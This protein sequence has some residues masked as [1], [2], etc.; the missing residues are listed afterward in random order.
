M[1]WIT[2]ALVIGGGAA[3]AQPRLVLFAILYSIG[4][5]GIMTLNDFKAIEGDRRMNIAS[6]P[7]TLGVA[8]A[9][10]VACA[11]MLVPQGIVAVLLATG[12]MPLRAGVIVLLGIGQAALMRRFAA[13]S[14]A[15]GDVV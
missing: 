12:G 4:A 6:L 2:G 14:G 13:R 15:L 3:L 5:H 1:A 7:V 8:T 10:R 9:A 11:I